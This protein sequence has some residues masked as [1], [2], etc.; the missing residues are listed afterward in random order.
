MKIFP[1]LALMRPANIVTAIA[2]I[3]AGAA[4]AGFIFTAFSPAQAVDLLLLVI[5]TCGLYGGGVVFNDYFDAHI[6][7]VERP[8]RPIPSGKVSRK[9][10]AVL[11]IV[12]LGA[13]VIFA[14]GVSIASAVV[15]LIVALLALLYDKYAKHHTTFGPLVM[16]LCRSGN[17]LL[18][19]SLLPEVIASYWFMAFVPLVFIA[20]ITLTSQGEVFGNNKAG[21]SVALLLDVVVAAFLLTLGFLNMVALWAML[22]FLAFWAVANVSAKFRAIVKNRPENIRKAVKT[23]VLSLILL[24]ASYAAG[25]GGL[26]FGIIVLALLPVSLFLAKRFAVT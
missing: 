2:D 7:K 16:G 21:I 17:L 23:G 15:A 1:Y 13:G 4:I 20:A 6:D 18:G 5:S 12:L 9:N 3:L 10:A 25:F 11:G 8:E 14:L 24:N 19:M 22:P 26:V